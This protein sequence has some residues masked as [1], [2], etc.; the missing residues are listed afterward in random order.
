MPIDATLRSPIHTPV[1]PGLRRRAQADVARTTPISASSTLRRYACRSRSVAVEPEDRIADQLPRPVIGHV[2]AALDLEDRDV[3]RR[4]RRSLRDD[5]R[6]PSVIT[7]GCSTRTSVSAISS[8]CRCATSSC[9]SFQ[10]SPYP[11]LEIDDARRLHPLLRLLGTVTSLGAL[12]AVDQVAA[13]AERRLGR[14]H[15][16]L[17]E[18]RV[19]MDRQRRCRAGTR[20]SR[21][22][23]RPREIRSDASGADDVH[24][25][26][27]VGLP[28]RR[29]P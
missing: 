25:E 22:R 23:A 19:R 11:A 24:A 20:P 7:S 15:H 9:C 3:A 26:Q 6:R 10:T 1:Q 28:R 2:A 18:R 17:A 13:L 29:R 27:L 21:A 4:E 5:C 14:L 16:R 8:R 12:A